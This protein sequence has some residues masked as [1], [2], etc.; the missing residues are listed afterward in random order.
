MEGIVLDVANSNSDLMQG[1]QQNNW[2]VHAC[3][4]FIAANGKSYISAPFTNAKGDREYRSVP[5]ANAA[6]LR[7]DEWK[8]IDQ[9]VM[10]VTQQ[11][12]VGIQDLI[13]NGLTRTIE[14][15]AATV[16]AWERMSDTNGAAL[17]M[18]GESQGRVD[19]VTY[20]MQYLPLPI[21]HA[22][23]GIGDRH[24]QM[25]RRLGTPLDT[26]NIEAKAIKIED[27]KEDILF[28]GASTFKYGGGTLYGYLDFPSRHT[29]AFQ[30]D[31]A[32]ALDADTVDGE[33]VLT[34]FKALLNLAATK[35]SYGPWMIYV[36]QVFWPKL[37]GDYK[38]ASDKTVLQRCKELDP[39]IKDIKVA[40][41]LTAKKIVMV[42]LK[43]TVV[44]LVRGMPLTTIQWQTRQMGRHNFKLMTIEVPRLRVDA[45]TNGGIFVMA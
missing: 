28:N 42:E 22:E 13:D 15:Y 43:N 31:T 5:I 40:P 29:I 20:D 35:R 34:N 41:A 10:A 24:L 26:A 16:L 18:D 17:D 23:V 9:Q 1:L 11:K 27:M 8:I 7:Y 21:I 45:N 4:P 3:R 6:T 44:E 37:T 14:G 12:R 30:T 2:N 36:P 33:D 39:R 25:S 32:A 38:A 19:G